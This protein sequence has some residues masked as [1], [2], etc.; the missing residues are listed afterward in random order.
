MAS[1]PSRLANRFAYSPCKGS[2]DVPTA[3]EDRAQRVS[4]V[5]RG[6][7]ELLVR[8]REERIARAHNTAPAVSEEPRHEPTAAVT[9]LMPDPLV[10]RISQQFV[11][12][13]LTDVSPT[14]APLQPRQMPLPSGHET[15]LPG[16]VTRH[17][18][19]ARLGISPVN[20]EDATLRLDLSVSRSIRTTPDMQQRFA[21]SAGLQPLEP[22]K[23]DETS[24]TSEALATVP[25]MTPQLGLGGALSGIEAVPTL[26][27]GLV[28]RLSQAGIRT[29]SDLAACDATSIRTKL[30]QLG[31][32]VKVEDWIAHARSVVADSA[33]AVA[34]SRN[35]S[36]KP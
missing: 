3:R 10:T 7:R 27:P 28:W 25:A 17:Y 32:L 12:T 14:A 30:G 21:E 2:D 18:D 1:Q 16:R 15:S 19:A 13:G 4:D 9:R 20:K 6:T 29:M 26:G 23:R 36:T 34:R 35:P 33:A 8:I 24:K 22:V 5:R 31:R 11:A